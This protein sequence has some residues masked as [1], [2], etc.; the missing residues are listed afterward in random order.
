MPPHPASETGGS[1]QDLV[2]RMT[3]LSAQRAALIVTPC[4]VRRTSVVSQRRPGE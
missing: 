2:V 3:S 4:R 1:D